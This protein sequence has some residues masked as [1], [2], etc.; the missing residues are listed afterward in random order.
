MKNRLLLTILITGF[1]IC[2]FPE[3]SYAKTIVQIREM[4]TYDEMQEDIDELCKNFPDYVNATSIGKSVQNRDLTMIKIGNPYAE[5][6][7]LIQASLHGREYI[8]TQVVMSI[9]EYYANLF[10][11][12][13]IP[14][15]YQNTC[16]YVVPMAN[17][18]GVTIAQTITTDWKANANGVDLNRNFDAYWDISYNKGVNAPYKMDFKGYFPNSEPES[19]ALTALVDSRDWD[20]VIN[21]HMRGNIIY[22]DDDNVTE[23]MSRMSKAMARTIQTYNRYPMINTKTSTRKG[24][25]YGGLLD[26]CMME[27]GIPGCTLEL[28]TE[29]CARGQSQCPRLVNQNKDS[30]QS[31]ARLFF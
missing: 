4:Y 31:V 13:E 22:Y 5:H 6:A 18:D 30:W 8:A 16:F 27:K 14:D 24:V 25:S 2:I 11:K 12:G 3:K 1:L 26:Y 21:Y 9:S 15:V 7:V 10:S 19:K 17:P 29:V 28:G 23:A 20:C